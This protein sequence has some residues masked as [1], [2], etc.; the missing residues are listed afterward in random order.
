MAAGMQH[1]FR[2]LLIH[3]REHFAATKD[4]A[5][6]NTVNHKAALRASSL[7]L[8]PSLRRLLLICSTPCGVSVVRNFLVRCFSKQGAM[9]VA[10]ME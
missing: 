8:L 4:S 2:R 7:N 10:E 6:L 3:N 5:L 1:I 9:P